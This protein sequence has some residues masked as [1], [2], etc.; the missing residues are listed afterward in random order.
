MTESIK[1]LII[2]FSALFLSLFIGISGYHII[3]DY[4]FIDA[5]YMSVIT[6]STVGFREVYQLSDNGKL[7]TTFYII[8]NIGIFA[9][10]ITVISTFIFEGE[11]RKIYKNIMIG[12]EVKKMKNH[13]IVCGF[14]RN[15]RK[16]CEELYNSD[17][18]FIIIE[19]DADV[20]N[21]VP[22]SDNYQFIND[23]ATL[24]KT[25]KEARIHE[26]STIITTLPKDS[27]NVFIALTA[28]ELNPNIKIIARASDES[29]EKKLLRAGASRIV[30][31]D[32]LGGLHMAQMETKPYVIEF[33]DL[34]NGIGEKGEQ[35]ILQDITYKDLK[36][37][38]QGQ[39]LRELDIRSKTGATVIAIKE[40]DKNFQFNPSP[41]ENINDDDILII[42]G[43]PSSID[44][45]LSVYTK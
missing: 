24:D 13:V 35:L 45:F 16:A 33:L 18:S 36:E 41:D 31:P 17:K 40:K 37:E 14:G 38:H 5:F 32:M 4:S 11:L 27:D 3:E 7:F 39:S 25:L 34:L 6:L 20:I 30:M 29:S 10:V 28:R 19:M 9:Y 42:F 8:L 21:R 22:E 23:D 2:S 43:T 12:R 1:K 15:G 26:A 44:K